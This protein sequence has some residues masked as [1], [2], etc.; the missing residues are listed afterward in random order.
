M[1]ILHNI[2]KWI[3]KLPFSHL[4]YNICLLSWHRLY[5]HTAEW[6]WGRHVLASGRTKHHGLRCR[7]SGM[8]NIRD[9]MCHW[10]TSCRRQA[11][12]YIE[13]TSSKIALYA[14]SFA[15]RP[16]AHV[17]TATQR[18]DTFTDSLTTFILPSP[19]ELL[20]YNETRMCANAQS[21]GSPAEYR[22]CPLFNV[23]VWLTPTTSVPCSNAAKMQNPLKFAGVPQT[24]ERISAVKWDCCLTS[25]FRLSIHA[26]VAKI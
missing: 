12:L 7:T 6:H 26:L 4:A 17:D 1:N 25:F 18:H 23:T 20:Q 9:R 19:S 14:L 2:K 15:V 3:F 8:S 22:W 5:L 16:A 13:N 24:S 10:Y 11:T 21:D